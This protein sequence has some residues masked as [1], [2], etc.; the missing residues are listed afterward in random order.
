[1]PHCAVRPCAELSA[2]N[3]AAG[4]VTAPAIQLRAV[5]ALVIV[6]MVVKVLE[7]TMT[8]VVVGSS[9][10]S[11]SAMSAPSTFET[12]CTRGPSCHGAK[13]RVAMAGPRSEPPMP[14]L[15]TSVILPPCPAKR[16]S[17]TWSANSRMRTWVSRTSGI[18]SRP[19]STIAPSRLRSAV[20]R[21]ARSSVS[22]MRVPPNMASRRPATGAA[23]SRSSASAAASM[24]VLDQSSTRPSAAVEQLPAR[25]ASASN[26][27]SMRRSPCARR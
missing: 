5:S 16:P 14:M 8:S 19:S 27:A 2:A 13:A 21:T 18:T 3:C 24:L 7:A 6:S 20:C 9:P 17:R 4:V 25:V 11:V 23:S 26:N 10:F 1:M 15:M 12:K 22:L